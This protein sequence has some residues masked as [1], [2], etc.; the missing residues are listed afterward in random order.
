MHYM[1]TFPNHWH[2]KPS[3][4]IDM[5]LLSNCSACCGQLVKTLITQDL[6]LMEYSD[7]ILHTYL[8]QYCTATGMQNGGEY[9]P[10]IILSGCGLLVKLPITL[11]PHGIFL[12]NCVCLYI[13][14]LS[15]HRYANL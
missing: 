14:T 3:F 8:F 7:Q 2:A 10:S 1:S 13:I 6:N 11:E 15:R 4:L 12:S 9:L 5:G